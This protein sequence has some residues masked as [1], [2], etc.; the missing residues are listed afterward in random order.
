MKSFQQIFHACSHHH[1]SRQRESQ[2]LSRHP[3]RDGGVISQACEPFLALLTMANTDPEGMFASAAIS[4]P[5]QSFDG[6]SMIFAVSV[7]S[8]DNPN[9]RSLNREISAPVAQPDRAT[10][11]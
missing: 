4:H 1:V 11:F 6:S 2:T 8:L 9:S 7:I 10:D 5:D 3:F